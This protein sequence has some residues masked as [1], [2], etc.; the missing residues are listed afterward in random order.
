M[1][2][3]PYFEGVVGEVGSILLTDDEEMNRLSTI[4]VVTRIHYY[5]LDLRNGYYD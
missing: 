5:N 4:L 1:M 2:K 3:V